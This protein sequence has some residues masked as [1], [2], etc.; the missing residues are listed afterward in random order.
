MKSKQRLLSAIRGE[1]VDR[2]P[3]SPFLAYY[4]EHLPPEASLRQTGDPHRERTNPAEQSAADQD[5]PGRAD[6]ASAAQ[7][8][9]GFAGG[10]VCHFGDQWQS[11]CIPLSKGTACQRQRGGDPG[12]KTAS[13][14]DL[15]DS[16]SA[17]PV[18]CGRHGS[19]QG[20]SAR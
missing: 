3:W 5:H 4:W 10:A 12:K 7:G 20:R 1:P 9:A 14:G 17:A 15:D 8:R 18:R 13:A 11:F 2:I 19:S 6:R 16:P